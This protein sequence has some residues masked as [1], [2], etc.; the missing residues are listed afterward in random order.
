MDEAGPVVSNAVLPSIYR[1]H[2]VT[3]VRTP[4]ECFA[5]VLSRES[6][7]LST[8]GTSEML[9]STSFEPHSC[10]QAKKI[11]DCHWG[12]MSV[13]SVTFEGYM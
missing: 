11:S 2:V 10:V 9:K 6:F 5:V 13:S 8:D 12:G 3:V 1:K 7:G 4:P